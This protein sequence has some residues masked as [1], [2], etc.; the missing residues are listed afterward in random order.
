M[1]IELSQDSKRFLT[2]NKALL[3]KND[4]KSFYAKLSYYKD[5]FTEVSEFLFSVLDSNLFKYLDA[6]PNDFMLGSKNIKEIRITGNVEKI[7]AN[8]FKD[9]KLEKVVIEDGVDIIMNSAFANC[10]NLKSVDLGGVKI[11]RNNAFEGCNS[12]R[13]IYLPETVQ[14]LGAKVF[15]ENVLIKSPPR[16]RNS[17]RFP[18]NELEWYKQHL[19]LDR[20]NDVEEPEEEEI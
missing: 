7:G 2:E 16:K 10:S 11:I 19:V 20:V 5:I 6:I 18:K 15:P 8:A 3:K 1:I 9:S 17:L 13:E 14:M 12:L 4:L